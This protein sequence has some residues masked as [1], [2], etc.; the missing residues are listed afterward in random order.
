MK[1][2]SLILF[3]FVPF[4]CPAIGQTVLGSLQGAVTDSHGVP[5]AGAEVSYQ[6]IYKVVKS[7]RG[8]PVPDKDEAVTRGSAS[9]DTAGVFRADNLP[10]GDYLFCGRVPETAYLDSCRWQSPVRVS[11]VAG[12]PTKVN[13]SLAKG[14]FVNVRIN[15]ALGLL[16]KGTSETLIAGKLLVGVHLENG[17]YIGAPSTGSD[18]LGK[19]Y[20]VTVPAG[21]PLRLWLFS[22]DVRLTDSDGKTISFPGNMLPFQA[23]AEKDQAFVF[24]VSGTQEQVAK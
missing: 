22:R 13:L 17:V 15:D 4:A 6:R 1:I 2:A 18:D 16:P 3:L 12:S 23:T 7:A 9:T 24:N 5:L 20:Q 11:V 8:L 14:V 19:D 21:I 10:V